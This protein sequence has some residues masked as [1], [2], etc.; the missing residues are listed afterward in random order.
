MSFDERKLTNKVSATDRNLKSAN[1]AG[2]SINR[3]KFI[4]N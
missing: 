2:L 4:L 3:K 1:Q